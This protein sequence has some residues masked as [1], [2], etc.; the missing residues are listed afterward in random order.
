MKKLK[1]LDLYLGALFFV[2]MVLLIIANV[3]LRYIFRMGISWAEELTLI[4]FA[5][6]TYLGIVAAVR[7]DQHVKMD[8]I[9]KMFPKI[10]QKTIDLMTEIAVIALG[11]YI[12]Y[13]SI[14]LCQNAGS[15]R[16]LVM[17]LPA[18]IVNACL[19]VSFVLITIWS[20]IRV[21]QKVRGTFVQEVFTNDISE[22]LSE[23]E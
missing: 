5:W 23:Y 14:I 12:S 6:S 1:N 19:I 16:T 15:K 3:I 22:D 8:I 21:V 4:L 2:A 10:V 17:R 7:Y 18:N 20:L 9:F 11:G 13:L